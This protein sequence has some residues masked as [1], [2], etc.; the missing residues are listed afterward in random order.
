MA[1]P[2]PGAARELVEEGVRAVLCLAMDRPLPE[3]AQAG[4][5]VLH[6]PIPDFTAPDA[7]TLSR[8]VAFVTSRWADGHS[9]AV[10]C[11]AGIGR[12]GTVLAACLVSTGVAPE[13]AIRTVR[14]QRPGSIET[15]EQ[16]DCV[17]AF[18]DNFKGDS[19]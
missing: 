19:T 1:N 5:V 3:L 12:T 13:E 2:R 6:E 10:H 4:L 17:F 11:I 8:C 15:V 14:R 18:A 16:E 7:A 9:V